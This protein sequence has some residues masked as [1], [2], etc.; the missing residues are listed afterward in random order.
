MLAGDKQRFAIE[1]EPET[2][3]E[4]WILG[5]FRFWL[6]GHPVGDWSDAA[7]LRGCAWH[8]R[9]FAE[10]P[11]DRYDERLDGAE[12]AAA[13]RLLHD[14]V[15]GVNAIAHPADQPIPHAYERFHISYLGMSSMEGFDLLLMKDRE[16]NERCLWRQAGEP[17]VREQRLGPGEMESVARDFCQQFKDI[18][19]SDGS[20]E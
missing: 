4:G 17:P 8:L 9:D 14:T 12:P 15:F 6:G 13:F 5:H 20:G 18:D 16:G 2:F 1:V 10:N 11:R 3:A 19:K 7:D